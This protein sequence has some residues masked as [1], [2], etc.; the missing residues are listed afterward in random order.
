M[1]FFKKQNLNPKKDMDLKCLQMDLIFKSPYRT[2][3]LMD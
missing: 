2:Q 1:Q 3:F